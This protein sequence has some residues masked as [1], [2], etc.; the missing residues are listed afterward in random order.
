MARHAHENTA[1]NPLAVTVGR[2]L[3]MD[4]RSMKELISQVQEY[5]PGLLIGGYNADI[6]VIAIAGVLS[7]EDYFQN[8]HGSDAWADTDREAILARINETLSGLYTGV[9]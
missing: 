7:K 6:I 3:G 2:D 9:I 4:L 8:E 5:N 1:I